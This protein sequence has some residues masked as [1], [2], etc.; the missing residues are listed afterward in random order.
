M[1]KQFAIL[2][3]VLAVLFFVHG[4]LTYNLALSLSTKHIILNNIILIK[5]CWIFLS[6]S[7]IVR[8]ISSLKVLKYSNI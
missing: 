5:I 4:W 8:V 1:K 7:L 3:M 6:S 2:T